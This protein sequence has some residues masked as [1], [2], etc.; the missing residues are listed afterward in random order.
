MKE[1]KD[2]QSFIQKI[3]L[4]KENYFEPLEDLSC[5]KFILFLFVSVFKIC[6]A[7]YFKKLCPIIQ[8]L[9]KLSLEF[10]SKCILFMHTVSW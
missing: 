3:I 7:Y 2:G 4:G 1:K 10:K 9:A 5:T 6:S 8:T